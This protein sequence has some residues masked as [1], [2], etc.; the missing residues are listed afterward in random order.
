MRKFALVGL[1]TVL[2]ADGMFRIGLTLAPGLSV[3]NAYLYL[4]F[5]G[6]IW[7]FAV[8]NRKSLPPLQ[9]LL[10]AW[11]LLVA[12]A[13]FSW[14][15]VSLTG[16]HKG[17]QLVK[18]GISLKGKVIDHFLFF[19]VFAYTLRDPEDGLKVA[20][21]F[22]A[23]FGL[24]NLISIMDI[25]NIPDLGIM[26]ERWDSRVAGPIGEVNQY[27]TTLCLFLPATVGMAV[28]SRGWM[29]KWLWFCAFIAAVMLGLTVSRGS[30]LGLIA[31]GSFG[32]FLARRHM[33][34]GM[35]GRIFAVGV[36]AVVVLGIGVILQDPETIMRR[37][38]F[39]E[40]TSMDRISS[41]R[42]FRWTITLEYMINAP[43][44]IITGLG[45][46]SFK[47]IFPTIK[48]PHNSYLGYLFNLGL[49]GLSLFLFLNAQIIFTV[50]RAL[51][52]ATP[53]LRSALI[54][55]FC[56]WLA[57]LT[58]L[59]FVLLYVP[60]VFIWAYAGIAMRLA[61]TA[62]DASSTNGSGVRNGA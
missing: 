42:L 31:G 57:M 25:Y 11:I 36:L 12:W 45:W 1:L 19:T 16:F 18:A 10:I 15:A 44:S 60:W 4:V 20:R 8:Q 53:E 43:W 38:T 2:L 56:G 37:F 48:D 26:E 61:C 13:I 33:P 47:V 51:S 41:G 22:L 52:V 50:R 3:K 24:A 54:G 29:A 55:F 46:D 5:V 32:L 34:P 59:F 27:G 17:Y 39:S 49:I 62:L 9:P 58:A 14:L 28:A 21:W 6:L 40:S 23:L 7:D 30:Y 35:V